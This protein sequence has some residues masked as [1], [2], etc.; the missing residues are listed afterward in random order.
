M[1]ALRILIVEDSD[2]DAKLLSVALSETRGK[3]IPVRAARA[4]SSRE[5]QQMLAGDPWD[6][7]LLNLDLPDTRG[8]VT[9]RRILR[10]CADAAVIVLTENDS[11]SSTRWITEGAQDVLAKNQLEPQSL[12][13]TMQH[14][15]ARHRLMRDFRQNAFVDSATGLLTRRSFRQIA[16]AVTQNTGDNWSVGRIRLQGMLRTM[17][18]AQATSI[19]LDLA[20]GL[21]AALPE[22][23]W[24]ARVGEDGAEVLSPTG[25]MALHASLEALAEK[26]NRNFARQK[27]SSRVGC[28]FGVSE[29]TPGSTVDMTAEKAAIAM[30]EN[31][32]AFAA[33]A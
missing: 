14:S 10:I 5:A 29:M 12:L 11:G 26:L 1:N 13:R 7:V 4:C 2:I 23:A 32:I 21:R 27:E 8:A 6:I 25:A 31:D 15:L 16:T 28:I 24:I 18:T 20:E 9:L 22:G 30:C 17:E 3:G 33:G 19:I